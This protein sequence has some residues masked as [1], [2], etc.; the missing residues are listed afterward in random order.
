MKKIG[1]IVVV[2]F[3]VFACKKNKDL[4]EEEKLT[5]AF[6]FDYPETVAAGST[7][8][9]DVN[10]VVDN[11]CGDFGKF[12]AIMMDG[13]TLE[14]R[15]KTYYKGCNCVD[16]FEEKSVSYPVT[17]DEAGIYQLKFWIAEDEFE[18]YLITVE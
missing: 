17:F 15:L 6:I 2:L 16:E 1:L 5:A 10:Y 3:A 8:I 12:D 11:S 14:V 9:L 7:F 18:S 13:N 4:C